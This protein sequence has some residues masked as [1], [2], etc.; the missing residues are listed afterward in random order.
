LSLFLLREEVASPLLLPLP[1]D[2]G[3]TRDR[4]YLSAQVGQARLAMGEGRGEGV[5][6]QEGSY[7]LTGSHAVKLAQTA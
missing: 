7:A 6:A 4:H 1:T 5:R 3:F 2:L